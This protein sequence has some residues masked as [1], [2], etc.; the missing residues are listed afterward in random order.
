MNIST[1]PECGCDVA[2]TWQPL[3]PSA[4]GLIPEQAKLSYLSEQPGLGHSR[5]ED[6]TV[7]TLCVVDL[8]FIMP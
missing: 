1:E 3:A 6:M 2:A 7:L 8:L 4:T 5:T